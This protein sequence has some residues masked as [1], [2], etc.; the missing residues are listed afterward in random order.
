MVSHKSEP[1]VL[2]K[3]KPVAFFYD[4]HFVLFIQGCGYNDAH[5]I[6]E[7]NLMGKVIK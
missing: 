6:S 4:K 1:D 2:K 3:K 7:Y 5:Q